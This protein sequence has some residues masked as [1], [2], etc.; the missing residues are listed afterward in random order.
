MFNILL[1]AGLAIG[2]GLLIGKG[3]HLLKITGVVGYILT[4]VL[5]GPEVLDILDLSTVEVDTITSFSLG[6]VAFIIGGQLTLS[7]MREQGRHILA[8][9]FGETMGAFAVVFV[10]IYLVTRDVPQSIVFAAMATASAPAGSVAIIREY[11]ARGKLT[12][13][14]LAVVGLDDGLAIVIY[15]FSMAI[16]GALLS[17][18]AF[19]AV[20]VL[21][22]PL[23]EI[24]GALFL[25]FAVGLAAS[26]IFRRLVERGEIIA[27]TMTAILITAGLALM[28]EVSLI[29]ACLAL[30]MTV[31]NVFP[32]VNQPV[33]D[34]MESISLPVYVLFFVVAG[35]RLH[36]SVLAGAGLVGLVY[37]LGRSAG[38]LT[39][40]Y[41]AARASHTEPLITRNIGLCTL[42]QA[43]VAIGLA[44][45]A[46]TELTA[47]GHPELGLLVVTTITATTIVFE[48]VGPLATWFA[49]HRAGEIGAAR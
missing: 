40:A 19:S 5:L 35:L 32:R 26:F 31:A 41:T 44:L 18:G 38:K 49:L 37:I 28:A 34:A 3:T 24:M 29:L 23:V 17:P 48:I 14:V 39:G 4:G 27:A 7:L 30:G 25:G 9:I 47:M 6:F 43:G 12:D 2:L 1:L 36:P 42:T 13:A 16:V 33:F 10:F 8:I 20:S 21:V 22:T 11:R 46:S 45:L 15:A